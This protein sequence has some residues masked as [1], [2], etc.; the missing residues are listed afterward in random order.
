LGANQ[1][2]VRGRIGFINKQSYKDFAQKYP[3]SETSYEQYISVLKESTKLIRDYILT[4]ELGFKL[5][6]SLGYI[7]VNKY[8]PKKTYV[9]FSNTRKLGRTV[10]YTNLHS[11]GYMYKVTLYRNE[12]IAPIHGYCMKA[13]R[14]L[15]R[16]LAKNIKGHL[17]NYIAID[18]NCYTKRFSIDYIINKK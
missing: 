12:R 17:Q 11:Y 14:I 5:P 10:P 13:H 4:N 9:D 3:N 18:K 8:K 6:L 7:A 15:K 1:N 16:M 2:K